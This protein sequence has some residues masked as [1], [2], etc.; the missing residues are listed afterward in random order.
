MRC[1]SKVFILFMMLLNVY[2]CGEEK[3]K[4]SNEFSQDKSPEISRTNKEEEKEMRKFY[5]GTW[6]NVDFYNSIKKYKSPY[7]AQLKTPSFIVYSEP[8]KNNKDLYEVQEY[9]YGQ[10]EICYDQYFQFKGYFLQYEF[11]CFDGSIVEENQPVP[12]RKMV[13]TIDKVENPLLYESMNNTRYFLKKIDAKSNF[14]KNS[15]NI[16]HLISELILQGKY[17][18]YNDSKKLISQE[19][20][21]DKYG[22]ISNCNYFKKAILWSYFREVNSIFEF[23]V[24]NLIPINTDSEECSFFQGKTDN[25]YKFEYRNDTIKLR[26]LIYDSEKEKIISKRVKYHLVKK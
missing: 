24:L 25:L 4:S 3:K 1:I 10:T 18:L 2:S 9:Y 11:Q 19:I 17:S 6:I 5:E 13:F 8:S 20:S 12:I 14:K 26:E 16:S 7:I 22:N 15:F 21:I 23:D